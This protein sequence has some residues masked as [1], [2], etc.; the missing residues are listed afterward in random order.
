MFPNKSCKKDFNVKYAAQ[1]SKTFICSSAS[2]DC[3][4]PPVAMF[5]IVH[6]YPFLEASELSIQIIRGGCTNPYDVGKLANHRFKSSNADV[7]R[8]IRSSKLPFDAFKSSILSF[9]RARYGHMPNF[10]ERKLDTM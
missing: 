8:H 6:P 3:H 4:G 10:T 9:S 2:W 7:D 1:S 5:P